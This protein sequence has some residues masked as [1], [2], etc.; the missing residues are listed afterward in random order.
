[1]I[2]PRESVSA[3]STINLP[4]PADFCCNW[5]RTS[6]VLM[7]SLTTDRSG[8]SQPPCPFP[9]AS[10][11]PRFRSP[12]P[13]AFAPPLNPRA[14]PD[15]RRPRDPSELAPDPCRGPSN[16]PARPP[17]PGKSSNRMR[18]LT[19]AR[20]RPTASATAW[21]VNSKS[22]T[23]RC[24]ARASSA[25][26]TQGPD[27][28]RLDHIVCGDRRRE[29]LERLLFHG[30]SRLRWARLNGSHR[31]RARRTGGRGRIA[32]QPRTDQRA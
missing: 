21:C 13:T 19:A 10:Y 26:A 23:S 4:L 8:A 20:E 12:A 29:L 32:L 6:G 27:E 5:I 2:V 28:N 1:M 25:G 14:V 17:R 15:R 18:L 16:P 24:R 3:N 11:G 9:P 7:T 31:R 30:S 22:M